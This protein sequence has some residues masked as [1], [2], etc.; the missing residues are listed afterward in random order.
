MKTTLDKNF[1]V[2]NDRKTVWSYLIDPEQIVVCV[3]GV[4]LTDKVNDKTYK[5][6]VGLKFGPISA[7]YNGEVV[8]EEVD[9]AGFHIVMVGKGLDSKGKGSA[10]MKLVLDLEENDGGTLVKS[11]MTVSVIGMVAQFGSRLISDVSDQIF[12]QF[13]NNFKRKLAGEELSDDD[14]NIQGGKMMGTMV[15]GLFGKK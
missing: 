11:S 9:E 10:E 6:T 2:E 4:K 1:D 14:R 12:N 3:P 5:G 7:S 8:Y 15:K 13:V